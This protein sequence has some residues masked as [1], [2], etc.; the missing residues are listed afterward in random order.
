MR[1]QTRVTTSGRRE[2][3]AANPEMIVHPTALTDVEFRQINPENFCLKERGTYKYREYIA[4]KHCLQQ[5]K[6]MLK[7]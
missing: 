4:L 3:E 1:Q 6:D 7:L 2:S 5:K